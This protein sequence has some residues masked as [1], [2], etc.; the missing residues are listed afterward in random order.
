MLG[1]KCRAASG[2]RTM[3]NSFRAVWELQRETWGSWMLFT[4]LTTK[5]GRVVIACISLLYLL[6][7]DVLVA[8]SM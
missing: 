6:G 3:G 8:A 2:Q 7:V 5:R 1:R 4:A